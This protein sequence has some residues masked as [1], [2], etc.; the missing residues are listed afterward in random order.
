MIGV[1]KDSALGAD[2]S[3]V[4]CHLGDAV[5]VLER[6]QAI[7]VHG[8]AVDVLEHIIKLH[9]LLHHLVLVLA[10]DGEGIEEVHQLVFRGPER[11][12]KP[13]GVERRQLALVQDEQPPAPENAAC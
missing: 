13:H 11:L 5:S 6:L 3:L 7:Y 2:E 10:Q 1:L 8:Q 12:P 4:A 9:L